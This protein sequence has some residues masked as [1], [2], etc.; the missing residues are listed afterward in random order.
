MRLF[1]CS[2]LIACGAMEKV[3]DE[4]GAVLFDSDGD[5]FTTEDDCDDTNPMVYPGTEEIC[6]GM[7]N[8]CNQEIDE[9]V[10]STFYADGDGDGYGSA[11]LSIEA[12]SSPEG[13]VSVGTDCDDASEVVFPGAEEICDDMDNDCNAEIDEG[14]SMEFF[15]DED[16]DGFGNDDSIV[17]ACVVHRIVDH[18]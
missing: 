17:E 7:D 13:F 10:T 3:N 14:L 16:E 4:Q 8:N 6:D 18:R 9:E 2:L 11:D 12:C 5:G 15:L 1:W